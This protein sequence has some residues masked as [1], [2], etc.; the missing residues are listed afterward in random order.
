[1]PTL[2]DYLLVSG[3]LFAIGLAGA[4]TRRNA[5]LVLIGIELMLNTQAVEVRRGAAAAD[6]SKRAAEAT[7][8]RA[9]F[10]ARQYAKMQAAMAQRGGGRTIYQT[11]IERTS[12]A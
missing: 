12:A 7:A 3:L 1:M 10:E 5:I 4:L 8:R 9:E 2:N 6:K 11:M